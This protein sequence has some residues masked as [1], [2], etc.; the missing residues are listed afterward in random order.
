MRKAAPAV[1]ETALMLRTG[2][3]ISKQ[4]NVGLD[5]TVSGISRCDVENV[6]RVAQNILGED[7]Q[8]IV[9]MIQKKT[10]CATR[11][12]NREP[13]DILDRY[14]GGRGRKQHI[15]PGNRQIFAFNLNRKDSRIR[16]L[17]RE[18]EDLRK[19]RKGLPALLIRQ[20]GTLVSEGG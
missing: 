9:K 17:E 5:L 10:K 7:V 19:M 20:G 14:F 2:T 15:D 4:V 3:V 16:D 11:R 18:N 1:R 13:L 8:H 12:T 6:R